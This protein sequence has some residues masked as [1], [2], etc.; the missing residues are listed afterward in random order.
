MRARSWAM[1]VLVG[2]LRWSNGV[3]VPRSSVGAGEL[4]CGSAGALRSGVSAVRSIA[5]S[6]GLGRNAIAP[7]VRANIAASG[8]VDIKTSG[9]ST[10]PCACARVRKW[11]A[12]SVPLRVGSW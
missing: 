12:R 3:A 5:A 10:R 9:G 4:R 1:P 2:M 7:L 6:T 8:C 11:R